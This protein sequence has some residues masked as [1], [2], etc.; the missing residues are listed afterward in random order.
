MINWIDILHFM[1]Y[2]CAL[3]FQL[4]EIDGDPK[5]KEFLDELF[6]FM[7]E[8]GEFISKLS[9]MLMKYC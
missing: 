8:R 1:K 3:F 2:V 4:Y 9:V 6:R 5:R 7:Q